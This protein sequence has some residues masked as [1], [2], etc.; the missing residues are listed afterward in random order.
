MKQYVVDELRPEDHEKLK[1]YLEATLQSSG[2][3]ALYWVPILPELLNEIQAAHTGCQPFYFA[4][5]LEPDRLCCEFLV[6]TKT[7]V[8]CNCMTYATEK[9]RNWLIET[10]DAIF[11]KLEI[12]T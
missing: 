11:T 4:L 9:Q 12:I 7:R 1:G 10:V 2:V 6:R 8:R 5:E 3:D